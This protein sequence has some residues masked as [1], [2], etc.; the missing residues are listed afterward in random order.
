MI[1]AFT[2]LLTL[3]STAHTCHS[4]HQHSLD[5]M[6]HCKDGRFRF[7]PFQKPECPRFA[8]HVSLRVVALRQEQTLL[9]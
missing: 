3:A 7:H 5:T 2:G 9:C 1:S 6:P 4:E 8:H